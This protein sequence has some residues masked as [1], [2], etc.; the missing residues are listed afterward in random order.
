MRRQKK[1]KGLRRRQNLRFWFEKTRQR[2]NKKRTV[3]GKFGKTG[4]VPKVC[5]DASPR[6]P[7]GGQVRERLNSP[8]QICDLFLGANRIGSKR[9]QGAPNY[10]GCRRKK[11]PS[12]K[13][14]GYLGLGNAPDRGA[15]GIVKKGKINVPFVFLSFARK[16]GVK[17]GGGTKEG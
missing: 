12:A 2:S 17:H 14:R 1:G 4:E 11:V 13:G 8:G 16:E 6:S 9:K 7:S 15:Q 3:R 5:G 10:E